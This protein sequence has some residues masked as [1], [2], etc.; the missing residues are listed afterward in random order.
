[1][2]VKFRKGDYI[3]YV[4]VGT[5]TKY[6]RPHTIRLLTKRIWKVRATYNNGRSVLI[7]PNYDAAWVSSI[8]S[9]KAKRPLT[10]LKKAILR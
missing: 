1:M 9:K 2:T 7:G 3:R 8:N 4:P 6:M 10:S 5:E